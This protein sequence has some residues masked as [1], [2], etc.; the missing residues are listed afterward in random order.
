MAGFAVFVYRLYAWPK[1][2]CRGAIKL[3]YRAQG[4]EGIKTYNEDMVKG[5]GQ[6][7]YMKGIGKAVEGSVV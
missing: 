6:V 7:K 2:R 1:W 4:T 3:S 5:E